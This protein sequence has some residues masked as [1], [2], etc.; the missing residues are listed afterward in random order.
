VEPIAVGVVG[1]GNL[2]RHHARIYAELPEARL[3]AVADHDIERARSVARAHGCAACRDASDLVGAVRAASVAVP[4]RFHHEVAVRL[5][6]AGIDVLVEKPLARTVEEA[7]AINAA[8]ERAT[9]LV[10]VGH[11]ERFNPAVIA[12]TGVVQAPRFFEI[13]RLASFTSR[14]TDIDVVLDLMIHD[15]DIALALDGGAVVSVEAVG[16]H[17]LT[18][19]VD[20]ANARLTFASGCVANITASRI[21][22]TRTRKIRVF[23]ARSYL[24][25]DCAERS[26]EH[27][28]LEAPETGG[29]PAIVRESVEVPSVEPLRAELEA[30]LAAASGGPAYAVTAPAGRAALAVA[31]LVMEKIGSDTSSGAA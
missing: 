15:I 3:V 12:L 23:Q 5:L 22:A 9:R 2:G 8:A 26:L 16:V 14:S 4:T 24:S 27:Y 31:L 1:V 18:P 11:S 21:S 25:C 28:R 7:E 6:S 29:R 30:F 20:I 10:M 13:H 19:R 17:A